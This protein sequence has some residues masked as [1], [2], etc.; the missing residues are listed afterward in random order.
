M[1]GKKEPDIVFFIVLI[2]DGKDKRANG[3]IFNHNSHRNFYLLIR[4]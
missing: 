1:S 2:I 4:L 3:I